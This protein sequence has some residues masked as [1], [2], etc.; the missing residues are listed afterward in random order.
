MA[1]TIQDNS[2][3]F[4]VVWENDI[5]TLS[6]IDYSLSCE[7]FAAMMELTVDQIWAM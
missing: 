2:E 3:E 4:N 5:P 6:P 7:Q 1:I